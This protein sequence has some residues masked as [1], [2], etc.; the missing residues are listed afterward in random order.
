MI[1]TISSIDNAVI[2]DQLQRL[3]DIFEQ[4]KNI[5]IYQRDIEHLKREVEE[6][7]RK[8]I[9]VSA[10]GTIQDISSALE[11]YFN[12][13]LKNC[14][15]LMKD[16]IEITKVFRQV[17]ESS[18]FRVLFTTVNT[19]MCRRFHT[20]MNDL[21][22]LCT[23]YGPGTLWLPENNVNRQALQD[24]LDNPAIIRD[25]RQVQQVNTGAVTLLKGAIFPSPGTHAI[26]HRSPT[27]EETGEKRLMLRVDTNDFLGGLMD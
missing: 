19:N 10:S 17:T 9:Q 24:G 4:E 7:M 16:I 22:L 21:R 20:D 1:D 27:I 2:T 3:N 13:H 18:S 25:P 8:T 14:P 11:T 6:A 23:Y 12:T 15:L 5:A 26:V